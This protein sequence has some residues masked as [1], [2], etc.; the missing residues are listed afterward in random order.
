MLYALTREISPRFNECELTHLER[1]LIDLDQARKQHQTYCTLL[2]ELGC[3]VVTLPAEESMP[4]SVFVE[5]PAIVLENL[6]VITRPGAESRRIETES[7]EEALS[8]YRQIE[9]IVAPG[10][11]EGGDVI[12]VGKTI[13]VGRSGRSNDDGI[14][15][16]GALTAPFGYEVKAV[17]MTGC[18]HLKTGCSLVA[19]DMLLVN[20]EWIDV[21]AFED[22]DFIN[23]HP[24][25]EYAGNALLI[26]E[27]IIHPAAHE[28]T[29]AVLESRGLNVSPVEYDELAK[30]E[31]GVTCCSIIFESDWAPRLVE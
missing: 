20:R 19:P 12:V 9:R 30:A 29:R 13:Y 1:T 25:E 4:D 18:L 22:I 3:H 16:L 28:K 15:Q 10:T 6:A 26:G 17:Q 24:D 2:N 27:N 14:V 31:S 5:D 11:I 23:A 8:P 21:G 7:M